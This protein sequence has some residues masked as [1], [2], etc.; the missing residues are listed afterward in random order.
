MN[1][2]YDKPE[3]LSASK[4][5]LI[6]LKEAKARL[7]ALEDA[8]TEL[9]AIV[10]MSCRFPGGADNPEKFW[11]LLANGVDAITEIPAAR[12]DVDAYYDPNPD[13]P[14][15]MYTRHGGFL[16]DIEQFDPQFFGISPREAI[17]IDPQHR[18]LLEVS[19]EA[20]ENA[21]QVPQRLSGSLTGVF[22]GITANEYGLITKKGKSDSNLQA[23]GVTG[24]PLNAA[25][26]RLSYTFGL[27]GPS[28]AIDTACSSSLVAIH[29]ACQ[30]L[31]LQECHMAIAGGVN[32]WLSPDAFIT[33]SQSRSLIVCGWSIRGN[34]S[35]F[36]V[37]A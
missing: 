4:Q 36:A 6:A 26:G 10:G 25:A 2:S 22:V 14:G 21:G 18:L 12:W 33:T 1:N 24:L 31:R 37:T 29:Q 13:T 27:T 9:I 28:L 7:Q 35:Y 32:S 3:K 20:L 17:S 15:K 8:K 19:W 30:S 23:Y 16:K 34:Q 5:V 11:E